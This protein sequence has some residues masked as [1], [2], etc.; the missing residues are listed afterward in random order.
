MDGGVYQYTG[1]STSTNRS[2]RL[3]NDTELNI[4]HKDAVVTMNGSIE[5]QGDLT[6]DGEGKLL[7]NT[8]D[9]F[10]YDG[11][12]VMKGGTLTLANKTV[13]DQGIGT[14]DCLVMAGGEFV[15][16]GKN[17]SS[18]TYN[19]PI[20]AKAGT[21]STVNFDLWNT[22][23]CR[24]YGTGTLIWDV[25]YLRE[26]I[27]GNWDDFT[28][29][30]IIKGTGKAGQSQFAVRNG[31]GVKN[32]SITLTGNAQINGGKN[33]S[34]FYLGG[35]SGD[36][37]TKL[38]G[39]NVK[40]KG[41]GTWVVG[42]ANTNETFRGVIDNNDQA[43][44]HPGTTAIEKQGLGDWRLTGKNVYSGTTYVTAGRLIVNGQH[45]GT[46]AV[47]VRKGATLAGTG[48]L[49]A[50]VTVN[51]GGMLQVGDTLATDKGLTFNGGLQLNSGAILKLNEGMAEA[52]YQAGD[53]IK[54]FTGKVTGQFADILPATPGDGLQWD[55]TDL[56]TYGI[57][58]VAVNTAVG[59]V[60][61]D[62][63]AA[64]YYTLKGERTL[65]PDKGLY[66]KRTKTADGRTVTKK[67]VR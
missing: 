67:V 63:T 56:Y 62:G 28:G 29:Q 14:A 26:Y 2:A 48:S 45:S 57:L 59:A 36:E 16:I 24:V 20:E 42:T 55:T 47:T 1:A 43:G 58:K 15:T 9:F 7:I 27:E 25:H 53:E 3:Y 33:A 5:G 6:I 21:T 8:T 66:L 19:F 50:K 35:L 46:G 52:D 32:A 34:T 11:N 38:S 51:V 54:V 65:N 30:L 64:E 61:T 49:A 22:N 31:V 23:K 12:L 39:F 10:K 4:A 60:Q 18:V 40:Q 13:S 37:T 44:T 17:E 41:E